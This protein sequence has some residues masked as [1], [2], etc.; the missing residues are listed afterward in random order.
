[1]RRFVLTAVWLLVASGAMLAQGT[2]TQI[3][4]PGGSFTTAWGVNTQGDVVGYC[5]DIS[6]QHGFILSAGEFTLID[7]PNAI[8]T[9]AYGI[10]DIGQVVGFYDT[11]DGPSGFLYS[12]QT[13]GLTSF[14]YAPN[15]TTFAYTINNAGTIAGTI[16][17]YQPSVSVAFELTDGTT[18]KL[19]RAPGKTQTAITSLNDAGEALVLTAA[20]D[21]ALSY[22]LLKQDVA[23]KLNVPS[24]LH[25][26]GLNNA[27]GITGSRSFQGTNNA[28]GFVL[29]NGVRQSII[30]PGAISTVPTALNDV[31]QV[32]GFFYDTGDKLHGFIWTP[33]TDAPTNSDRQAS[34]PARG[35]Q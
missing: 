14:Q 7:G 33:P 15:V 3:D 26:Y 12:I 6:A 10:N 4:C 18:Y 28:A 30:F 21:N 9:F 20:S 11:N 16:E 1:M 23:H 35:P 34:S 17:K 13:Q 31:G 32:V 25:P 19:F 29:Q 22:F 2:Y 27:G 24:N 8:S 5:Q